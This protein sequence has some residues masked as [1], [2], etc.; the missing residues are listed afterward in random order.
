MV[1][2]SLY[3][4]RGVFSLILSSVK[5]WL[6]H[7]L[8]VLRLFRGS[9]PYLFNR[10]PESS[11]RE[12]TELYPDPVSSRTASDLPPRFRGLLENR[13]K[14]C[15]GCY[16]CSK[17]CPTYAIEMVSERSVKTQKEWVS[18]YDINHGRCVSC[19]ICV[20]V[21]PTGSLRFTKKFEA[22]TDEKRTLIEHFG[23]GDIS[24][25]GLR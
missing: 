24:D 21:C 23:L 10:N 6:I 13:I 18:I 3:K 17:I 14:E 15:I 25:G 2:E 7:L 12:L 22:A 20:D 4:S 9:M 8:S 5:S 11:Y 19:G 16:E 1:K